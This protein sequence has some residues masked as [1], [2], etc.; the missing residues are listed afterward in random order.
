M[1]DIEILFDAT[2][3]TCQQFTAAYQPLPVK[4]PF[5]VVGFLDF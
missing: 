5:F 3:R 2:V 4:L 1:E